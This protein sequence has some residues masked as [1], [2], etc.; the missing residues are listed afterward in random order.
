MDEMTQQNA[1]L[2]EEA[3]AAAESMQSQAQQLSDSVASFRVDDEDEAPRHSNAR[4]AAPKAKAVKPLK[5]LQP[6]ARARATDKPKTNAMKPI[7]QDQ[8][9]WEEF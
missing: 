4:L 6:V 2:V 9:E 7:K 1:A 3:A 8:D 5:Q